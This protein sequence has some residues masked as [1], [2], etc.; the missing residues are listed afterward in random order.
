MEKQSG[1]KP[2]QRM[3]KKFPDASP[4]KATSSTAKPPT[5][6]HDI[7]EGGK[8]REDFY[9]SVEQ[10]TYAKSKEEGLQLDRYQIDLVADDQSNMKKQKSVMRWDA[11]KKKYLP[12][13]V[14]AEGKVMRKETRRNESGQK[15]KGVVEKS[16]LYSKWSKQSKGRIQK[17]GEMEI[18]NPGLLNLRAKNSGGI[19]D[20]GGDSDDDGPSD[21]TE[22]DGKKPIVP[23]HGIVEDKHLTNK[24]KRMKSKRDGVQSSKVTAA[25][26]GLKARKEIKNV[27]DLKKTKNV[28]LKH[29]LKTNKKFR[30]EHAK[31]QK[32]A[33]WERHSEKIA[34]RAARPRSFVMPVKEKKKRR[35]G[36]KE[37]YLK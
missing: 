22:G 36:K 16:D 21:N 26:K 8:Y 4:G 10:D 15:M 2:P 1:K 6:T 35:S 28:K 3:Q 27:D 17:V 37:I 9:V 18:S 31:Q 23:F 20:F 5:L 19:T 30:K 13:L 33:W 29:K 12:V 7:F 14:N 34:K 32:D 11:K 25:G 24:Q